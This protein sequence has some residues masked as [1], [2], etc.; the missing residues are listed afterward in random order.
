MPRLGRITVPALALASTLATLDPAGALAQG[1]ARSMD[2]DV[3]IR[4]AGMAGASTAVPWG[5]LDHWANPALLGEA[6]GIR[7]VHG[8]T[9]LLPELAADMSLTTDVV[10]AG[11]GG[12][13]V[14]FSGRPFDRGGVLLDYGASQGTD[15]NG[16]PTGTFRSFE[17]VRS[18][19]VGI[20]VARAIETAFVVAGRTPPALSRYADVSVGMNWKHL[21][22]SLGPPP[23]GQAETDA[24]DRGILGRVTP[25]DG[26]DHDAPLPLRI[27]ATYGQSILSYNDDAVV[28][29]FN[30]DIETPVSRHHRRGGAVRI[31]AGRAPRGAHAG[32]FAR[33]LLRGLTPLV[34]V[35][36]SVDHADIGKHDQTDYHTDGHGFEVTVANILSYRRGHY[37]DRDGGIDGTTTG[38]GVALPIGEFL[39]ASYDEA[40]WPQARFLGFDD[41]HRRQFSVWID[42]LAI[43]RAMT[44]PADRLAAD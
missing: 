25:I 4:S 44:R 18:W 35:V 6:T 10:R 3:S 15:E 42:P 28:R 34:S 26:I 24:R 39:G 12:F 8:R 40:R 31:A 1:T 37:E 22:M 43:R 13:G 29:F 2:F 7:F 19:G 41:L 27:D 9:K 30:A 16:N 11:A 21:E 23:F 20:S 5:D 38:W 14:V 33:S 32:V 17:R 36:A